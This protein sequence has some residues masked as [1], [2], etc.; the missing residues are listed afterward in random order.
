MHSELWNRVDNLPQSALQVPAD[1]QE[2][3][4]STLRRR[5]N[6]AALPKESGSRKVGALFGV[7][8]G[9]ELRSFAESITTSQCVTRL[10]SITG[11]P[12]E[13][14]V[15]SRQSRTRRDPLRQVWL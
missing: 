11:I 2:D 1:Q 10:V 3:L 9:N 8:T 6:V 12:V 7:Q 4:P 15:P 13:G 14:V 5:I